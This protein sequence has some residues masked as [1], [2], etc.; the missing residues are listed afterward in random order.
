MWRGRRWLGM[1]PKERVIQRE[2]A[3]DVRPGPMTHRSALVCRSL[4]RNSTRRGRQRQTPGGW[5]MNRSSSSLRGRW[6]EWGP[7]P[8]CRPDGTV[9]TIGGSVSVCP[10]YVM[11]TADGDVG[12]AG[13][14]IAG[15]R[16]LLPAVLWKAPAAGLLMRTL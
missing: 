15:S 16:K 7:V 2:R 1:V 8:G 10:S 9:W 14:L 6:W 4:G 3:Q 13:R 5:P 12:G 11:N